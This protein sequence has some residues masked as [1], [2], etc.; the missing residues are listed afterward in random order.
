MKTILGLDIGG[1]K[2]LGVLYDLD[3][4]ELAREKKKTKAN[5]GLEVVMSQIYKVIDALKSFEDAQILAIGAGVPGI[6]D[7]NGTVAFSPNIPFRDFTLG[8][9]LSERYEVPVYVGNDVNVAMY[10]EYKHLDSRASKHVLGIFIGTGVG[11]AIIIDGKLYTGQGSAGE[12]GHMVVSADGAYCGCGAQGCL[13]AYASKTAIQKYILKQLTKGRKSMFSD[14]L[15]EDGAVLKSSSIRKAYDAHDELAKE[16]VDRLARYM[17]IAVG[18]LVNLYHPEMIIIG[19]GI[20]EALG[21]LLLEKIISESRQHAMPGLME[22]VNFTV[23]ELADEA[24][25]FGAYQLAQN[26]L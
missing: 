2:I 18:S 6:V 23:S 17:G 16:V 11:G 20:T 9:K 19:G 25:V 26:M 22:T 21:D 8:K 13:E 15:E 14:L 4:K 12:F 7:D 10:G 5:E 24:G 1:T 3:G